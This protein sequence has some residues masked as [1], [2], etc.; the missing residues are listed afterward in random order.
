MEFCCSIFCYVVLFFILEKVMYL[1]I[2]LTI[3]FVACGFFCRRMNY[4]RKIF[5]CFS[6]CDETVK[7]PLQCFLSKLHSV[8]FYL[9]RHPVFHCL[10]YH[11][12]LRVI[13]ES[14]MS[15]IGLW[16]CVP[17]SS[18]EIYLVRAG[19]KMGRGSLWLLLSSGRM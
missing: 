7:F 19:R 14:D 8:C 11:V 10:P 5:V 3:F 2:Q 15:L 17:L 1:I 4:V 6:R 12:V 18:M 9:C 13:V 16:T